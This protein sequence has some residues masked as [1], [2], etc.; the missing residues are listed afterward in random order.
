MFLQFWKHRLTLNLPLKMN[1]VK[2]KTFVILSG[3]SV[4]FLN[5]FWVNES[6]L[7]YLWCC[8]IL[9]PMLLYTET[10]S[11]PPG[12]PPISFFLICLPSQTGSQNGNVPMDK[13]SWL[14]IFLPERK[15]PTTLRPVQLT[16]Y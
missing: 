4:I 6:F 5:G 9:I 7:C 11:A 8:E 15:V 12:C 14:E 1:S 10:L 16:Q 13:G 3:H 2:T